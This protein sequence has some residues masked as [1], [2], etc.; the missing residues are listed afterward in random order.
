MIKVGD[1]VRLKAIPPWVAEFPK[2]SQEVFA[3]CL[4]GV[5]T[6]CGIGTNSNPEGETNDAELW[7]SHGLDD[8]HAEGNDPP[9]IIWVEPEYL[10]VVERS[11]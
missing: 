4:G 1:R 7:A 9:E 2:G 11:G 6:V 10:E 5:F 8:P 3:Q